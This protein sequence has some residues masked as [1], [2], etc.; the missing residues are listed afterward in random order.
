MTQ[1]TPTPGQP[2]SE[3]DVSLLQPGD[4][5]LVSDPDSFLRQ[6][7]FP[8]GRPV[9]LR[10]AE[11][12]WIDLADLPYAQGTSPTRFTY[13]GRPDQDG[14]I[15]WS[16]G[17][18]PVPGV[19]IDVKLG[20]GSVHEN[21]TS[22]EWDWKEKTLPVIAYRPHAPVSRP[23]GEGEREALIEYLGQELSGA[24]DCKRVWSAWSYGTMGE[25][26]FD[27][28]ADRI[29]DIADAIISLLSPAAP[30][31]G[32]GDDELIARSL[33]TIHAYDA[34]RY[35]RDALSATTARLTGY[36]WNTDPDGITRQQGDAFA[37][38][39][40]V[41]ADLGAAVDAHPDIDLPECEACSGTGKIEESARTTGANQHSACIRTCDECGGCGFAPD[42]SALQ[43]GGE[44]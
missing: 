15:A 31:A 32:G 24:Y 25:D 28:V 36:D 27:P 35:L 3:A 30:D 14:W 40:K 11:G 17:E 10:S 29:E 23:A 26:D 38:A 13:L 4:W 19:R 8:E 41:F 21:C 1:T 42:D 37:A 16:G 2:L 7:G 6:R 9:R 22:R 44:R 39:D 18:N 20:N 5:L 12:G 34:V 43:P 33:R